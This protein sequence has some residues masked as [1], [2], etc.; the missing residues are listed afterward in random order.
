MKAPR[1]ILALGVSLAAFS[2]LHADNSFGRQWMDNYSQNPRPDDLV[3]AVVSLNNE[4]YFDTAAQRDAAIGFLSTVFQQNPQAV[5]HWLSAGARVLPEQSQRI[6]A[7]AAWFAGNPA[8]QRPLENLSEGTSEHVAVEQMLASGSSSTVVEIPVHSV[9]AMNMQWGAFLASGDQ[10][11]I[12][13]VFLALG[14]D[15]PGLATT[16]RY[17]LAQRAAVD[18]RVMAICQQELASEPTSVAAEF[19]ATLNQVSGQR[20]GA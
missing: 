15:Q 8:A 5:D 13:N 16:A 6:L 3:T 2:A 9:A 10:R 17:A 11:Y 7:A 18:P 4:G 20:P 14:S 12:Q 19:R 1:I